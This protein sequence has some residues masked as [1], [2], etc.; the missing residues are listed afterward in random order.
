MA[1]SNTLIEIFFGNKLTYKLLQ[2]VL[3]YFIFRNKT[4][5]L[6]FSLVKTDVY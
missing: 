3:L 1:K 6:H 4:H 5:L 2:C